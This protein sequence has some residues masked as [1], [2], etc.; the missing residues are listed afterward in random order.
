MVFFACSLVCLLLM[1]RCRVHVWLNLFAVWSGLFDSIRLTPVAI[2]LFFAAQPRL[3]RGP[4]RSCGCAA[5]LA[6]PALVGLAL[7][8]A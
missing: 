6:L 3:F 1:V 8:D 2:F 4:L 5:S 7:N